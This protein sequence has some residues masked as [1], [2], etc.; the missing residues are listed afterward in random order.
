MTFA[1]TRQN[2]KAPPKKEP[3]PTPIDV[4][5]ILGVDLKG[6]L[7]D[8]PL[9]QVIDPAGP[10]DRL[11]RPGD[12]A[13]IEQLAR[14]MGECGQLQPVMLERLVDGRFCRVFGR[15]RIAAARRLGW[16]AIRA[17]V[18]APLADDVR[19]T[20]VAIENVQRQDLTPA[21]ETLA[22]DELMLLQAFAAAKRV[23]ATMPVGPDLGRVVDDAVVTRCIEAQGTNPV[24]YREALLADPKVRLE[25]SEQVAA[26]LG[27]PASWVR[28]RLYIG[29]LS[30]RSKELVLTGKLPLAHA[31]EISK[32]ADDKRRDD[33]CKAYAAGGSDSISD[34]EA[35]QL[36][37]LQ[38]E[39]RRSVFSLHVVPWQRHVAFAGRQPCEGCPHNSAT[40][41][42][43][44]EGGGAV[45]LTM[46]GGRGTYDSESA[47]SEKVAAAG[48]C[49]LPACYQDKLRSAKGA[50]SAAS[51]R[52]VDG[53]KK[54]AEAKVPEYVAPAALDRKVR[55]R[56]A[57]HG[58]QARKDSQ[59][60]QIEREPSKQQLEAEARRLAANE[61]TEA[62]RQ[63]AKELEPQIAAKVMAVPGL[64]TIYTIL[65]KTKLFE[66]THHYN[67][68]K[69]SRAASSPAMASLLKHLS[70]PSWSA[71]AAIEKDC[72]RRFGL[73]D[74]WRD[75]PSG[76]ADKIAAAL[77]IEIAAAP[78]VDS[79]LPA[80]LRPKQDTG[81]KSSATSKA[82]PSTKRSGKK[83]S[84][85]R[86]PVATVADGG[87]SDHEEDD[88]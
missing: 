75:G 61:W 40:N 65:R 43:L 58:P 70:A 2:K 20:V 35:G 49:T 16:S 24:R 11:S 8:V 87:A 88:E 34:V 18:V 68:E 57:T 78:T 29:R 33:L 56:R 32:V 77:G 64:W 5:P 23:K 38:M 85:A 12:D 59:R 1:A 81:S 83:G 50:I 51:K 13:A 10:A 47:G 36:A 46:V 69:A 45:S 7:I 86:K 31:R 26:M 6:E 28:D 9:D 44:F 84:P 53:G 71:I 63:R 19:R 4:K 42:G 3:P 15:R 39:V 30:E 14:S 55:E 54:P 17:S 37:D 48:I 67:S 74:H 72:G 27:K 66:A 60:K 79:F 52:I 76:M 22:V 21:E 25:A 73:L 82:A 41:P 62:M 80:E